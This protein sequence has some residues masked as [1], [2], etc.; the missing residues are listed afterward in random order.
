M[1]RVLEEAVK[2]E[3]VHLNNKPPDAAL[4]SFSAPLPKLDRFITGVHV[5][6]QWYAA[7]F[8]RRVAALTTLLEKQ[9]REEL[10]AEFS[11]ELNV[12]VQR[13]RKQYEESI[14]AQFSRWE[15][16][17]Q[18]LEKEV[19]ELRRRVPGDVVFAEIAST[20]KVLAAST[21]KDSL[22]LQQ[23][24]PDASSLGRLLQSRVEEL[25]LKAYLR[26][27]KFHLGEK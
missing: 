4:G 19:A 27:L 3:A 7:D 20:A 10:R 21:D 8:E 15:S 11:A 23:L 13:L 5:L 25:T 2:S 17:R 16:Q 1:R 14:Y 9:I 18:A 12:H 22:E 24:M 6:E 26:G